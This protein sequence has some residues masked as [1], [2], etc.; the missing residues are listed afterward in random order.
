MLHILTYV[1]WIRSSPGAISRISSSGRSSPSASA[2]VLLIP[3]AITSTN[4][5]V[6]RLGFHRWQRLHRLTYLAG[7]LAVIHFIWRVKI[8]VSQ[9]LTYAPFS[10]GR[11]SM[12]RVVVWRRQRQA[13]RRGLPEPAYSWREGDATAGSSRVSR[14][15]PRPTRTRRDTSEPHPAANRPERHCRFTTGPSMMAP[16][17]A[18]L[19]VQTDQQRAEPRHDRPI[20]DALSASLASLGGDRDQRYAGHHDRSTNLTTRRPGWRATTSA[21]SLTVLTSLLLACAPAATA[22]S[23]AAPAKP[24]EVAQPAAPAAPAP[25]GASRASSGRGTDPSHAQGR[26]HDRGRRRTHDAGWA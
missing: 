16:V 22:A 5:S 14:C 1:C 25:A 8:D 26:R 2:L 21:I 23:T 9:P 17:F 13:T 15:R 6:R 19:A 10:W 4:G 7:V 24:A 11:C 3:L 20:A 12:V 18:G